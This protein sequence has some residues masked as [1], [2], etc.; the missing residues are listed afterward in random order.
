MIDIEELYRLY[1]ECTGICTDTRKLVEGTM[2]FALKGEHFDGND[3]AEKALEAGARYA[4]VDRPSLSGVVYGKTCRCVIVEDVLQALQ[5]MAAFHRS[6]FDIPVL[7][8]TGTNGKTTTKE[9]IFKILDKKYNVLYTQGNFNNDVG[10]P[11]TLLN[12]TART[13]FAVVEMG[14]SHPGDIARLVKIVNPTCG[15]ITNVGKAHL[16][17]FGS[18]EG[19]IRSKGELYDYLRQKGGTVFYN[20]DNP[21]LCKMIKNRPGLIARPY[22]TSEMNVSVERPT[23]EKPFLSLKTEQ[24]L[25]STKLIGRYNADNVL[26]ALFIGRFFE[27]PERNAI[28]AIEAYNPS[29]SRSQLVRTAEN[30]VIVDA[31]NANPT[32]MAASL[33]SFNE[34]ELPD[35]TIILGDMLELGQASAAEHQNIL[36][37]ALQITS[38]IFTVGDNFASASFELHLT[39]TV[40]SFPTADSLKKY[41]GYSPLKG[42]TILVK[43]SNGTHLQDIL[44]H[45]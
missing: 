26:C 3:Y 30:S 8:I 4:I 25:I 19:V 11:L 32:S 43:G 23:A 31:Y 34:L 37:S 7:G 29:N 38:S 22:G 40:K 41:L 36:K 45:L 18:L 15:V 17:G 6:Q 39:G 14:A 42:R 33:S 9:L 24:G 21:H 20:S 44:S 27:V 28:S 35:K 5:Q 2:F 13:Q 10:V 16:Q 1:K 12:M